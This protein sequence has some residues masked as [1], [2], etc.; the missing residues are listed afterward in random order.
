MQWLHFIMPFGEGKLKQIVTDVTWLH[1]A[2]RK[3]ALQ[4]LGVEVKCYRMM[5]G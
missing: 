1:P 4:R 3:G 5:K 2:I